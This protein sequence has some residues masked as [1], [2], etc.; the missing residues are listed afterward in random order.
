M[1]ISYNWLSQYIHL[2]ESPAEV[3]ELLTSIG[4][5][6]EGEESF[7]SLK[8]GLRGLVVGKI[9]E[10]WQ[11]PNADRLS[12]TK[13]DVGL[14]ELLPIVCGAPNVAEG[15]KVIV[16][17]VGTMLY[18]EGVDAFEIKK[19]K[20]RGEVS[21]G[22][23]C[24]EDEIGVGQSHDGIMILPEETLIGA[25]VAEIFK[26]E[27][28]T[29]FEIG[30][31]PNRAD[32][33]SHFG[34]ARDLK[35][36]LAHRKGKKIELC[37][38]SVEAFA[39]ANTDLTIPVSVENEDACPRY[40]GVTI[41]ELTISS[42]P[43]WLQN[44]LKAVGVR[45]TN[46]VVD[47]T[48]YINHAFGQPLHAF[49]ADKIDGNKIVVKTLANGSTFTTLDDEERKLN[50]N[51]LM[52]CNKNEG[53]CIAGV[54]GGV[55]SGVTNSTTKVFL[56]SAYF[57][58]VWVRKTAKR[59]AIHSDASFRFERG[60][61][62]N[63]TVYAAK[64]A[65]TMIAEIAGG[66]ISSNLSDTHPEAFP[67]F[68]VTYRL[69]K[70][71]AFIGHEIADS[72]TK[73]I[74]EGL[75]I[76]VLEQNR[77]NWLLSIPPF[78]VDVTREADVI[79]EVLRVYGY[80]AIPFTSHIKSSIGDIK[81]PATALAKK[82]IT[83][84]LVGNGFLEC[85]S[86]SMVDEKYSALS[87]E[88]QPTQVVRVNNP[89]SSEMGIMRPAM[90]FSVLQSA[91]YNLKRQQNNLKQFEFGNIYRQKEIGFFE[92]QR[93]GIAVSGNQMSDSWRLVDMPADWSFLRGTL[94]Q[95]IHRLGID[96]GKLKSE[97]TVSDWFEYGM[98][99]KLGEKVV[100][101]G[102]QISSEMKKAF[103]I[104]QKDV[105]YIEMR[106]SDVVKLRQDSISIGDLP[107]YPAVRR[108]LALLLDHAVNYAELERLAY[109][110]ERKLLKAVNLFDVYEGK[111]LPAGKKSYALA[112]SL[113][114]ENKTLT[115]K[116]VDK[117]MNR[118]LERFKREV[119]AELRG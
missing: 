57:N 73:R 85:M 100:I 5:E 74:L 63:N 22:M 41:S 109:Q 26:I 50:E 114:D 111:G 82:A 32:A 108:D 1:K 77:N 106:W 33:A 86:N 3:S 96:V 38:P 91:A 99:W 87:S 2:D 68:E 40:V 65:A 6:V 4:L 84:L 110:T 94:G 44:K 101:S 60:I 8:G 45:P 117:T 115:D 35:A 11:H 15:Q 37:R 10:K 89:L 62:P 20:I 102:G 30:L 14:A 24:A 58:P 56:E 43:D 39:S 66:K 46:N 55:Q 49:D 95:I 47:V 119:G 52:I 42:S 31:T 16:A 75:G 21:M 54:F 29:V 97:E 34:V 61:D 59:Q 92:E 64:L 113:R 69:D 81:P 88:W 27:T 19:S 107:K 80:D 25:S 72:D 28:D 105:Y 9:V 83:E 118:L 71:N 90:V 104:K 36:V 48:N 18:P 51:D 17:T 112:F 79:E 70:A 53:M 98:D 116:E 103:E 93:L 23:I 13:V 12:C 67:N 76:E 7:E 78:K